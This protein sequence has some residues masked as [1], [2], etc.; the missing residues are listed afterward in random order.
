MA[1][2][3]AHNMAA[4]N[5]LNT[6]GGNTKSLSKALKKVASG[7]RINNAGDDAS[8]YSISEKMK[9]QIR[10][11]GQCDQNTKTAHSML[12][13]ASKAVDEQVSIFQKVNVIALKASD[14]T[15]TDSDRATLQKEID[16]L[17]DQSES[18][19]QETTYNGKYLL[20]KR[21]VSR[22]DL[23]FDPNIPYRPN[24]KAEPV[25][26]QAGPTGR[27]DVPQGQYIDI[28]TDASG[29]PTNI[30][31]KGGGLTAMPN[32]GDFV[33][34][35]A[36]SRFVK[37][38]TDS[39]GNLM[40]GG[41]IIPNPP[42]GFSGA[43]MLSTVPATGT[44]VGILSGS[45]IM[46]GTVQ[47]DPRTG[48][49]AV[50]TQYYS[51]IS[52]SKMDLSALAGSVTNL[53]AGLDGLGFSLD[54]SGCD[55][56]VTVMFDASTDKTER[57]EGISGNPP[58]LCYKIGVAG[59]TGTPSLEEELGQRIFNGVSA[60]TKDAHG[61]RPTLPSTNKETTTITSRHDINLV[62]YPGSGIFIE[63][64]GPSMTLMNGMMG[65]LA[66]DDFYKPHQD[67]YVQGDTR[68]SQAT[69]VQV[70]NT[71]LSILF[72]TAADMW[73]IEPPDDFFPDKWPAEYDRY[74]SEAEKRQHYIDDV[75]QYP[76]HN[77]RLNLKN[78]VATREKASE[79]LEDVGQAIKYLVESNTTLGSELSRLDYMGRNLVTR[80]E[81][82]TNAESVIRDADMAKAMADF[83]KNNVLAQAAQSMLAQAN[84]NSSNVLSLL[85]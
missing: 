40:A 35:D 27:Y 9:A 50:F 16:Q 29:A 51:S 77:V 78:C 7:E 13:I 11:L 42:T 14:D 34:D 47:S 56:F 80:Y 17:L 32:V 18:I 46:T 1:M 70:P 52:I 72:P 65:G 58:P 71:T 5:A 38:T 15:Y 30:Y 2:V 22:T 62:Y 55:Q 61:S 20:N 57:F 23:Y 49:D 8:G 83:T 64:N 68:Q 81:N 60:T 41:K 48:N 76:G 33:W 6:L 39:S 10:A 26:A 85:Q 63:K 73:D 66:S 24:P 75:W 19:A 45:N 74:A 59:V 69:H 28:K 21:V 79:F 44:S 43:V 53:P 31:G 67:M 54:C 12:S 3:I 37:V 84:Q 25:I 36:D 82:T 4:L